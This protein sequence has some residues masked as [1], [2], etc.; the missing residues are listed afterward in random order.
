MIMCPFRNVAEH[1]NDQSKLAIKAGYWMKYAFSCHFIKCLK[2]IYIQFDFTNLLFHK[3][4]HGMPAE[5][6]I[7]LEEM[8][9]KNAD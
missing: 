2:K 9:G 3:K 5:K 7:L 8:D 6:I 1:Q 4:D